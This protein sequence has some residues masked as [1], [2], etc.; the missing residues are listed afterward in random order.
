MR[1]GMWLQKEKTDR[2]LINFLS[3][4]LEVTPKTLRNWRKLVEMEVPPR[5]GRPSYSSIQKN[6]SFK[7]VSEQ[8]KLQGYPGWRP[9][10]KALHHLPKR[11]VQEQVATIKRD[12]RKQIRTVIERNRIT[13]K[14]NTREAIWS[15]D[16]TFLKKKRD[17]QAQVIKDRGSL[18]YRGISESTKSRSE[19]VIELF[20]EVKAEYGLPLVCST[21]NGSNYCSLEMSEYFKKE[22]IIHL[23]S[24]PRTPEQNG[25]IEISMRLLKSASALDRALGTESAAQTAIEN[26][27]K[28]KLHATKGLK[29]SCALDEEMVV[30]YTKVSR[31]VFYDRCMERLQRVND[32]SLMNNER[33]RAERE[34]IFATLEEYGLINR[35]QAGRPY[36]CKNVEIFL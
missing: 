30:S 32:S 31:E 3:E 17:G 1:I 24:L 21:D 18:A 7:L 10:S 14:V 12:H 9:I 23:R 35:T 16:G 20:T 28:Y 27:N 5:I 36:R 29:T 22:K 13:T 15:L 34:V 19:D 25:A 2:K 4:R 8:M 33:R 11:L 6:D 26:L